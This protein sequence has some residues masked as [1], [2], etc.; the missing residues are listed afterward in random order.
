MTFLMLLATPWVKLGVVVAGMGIAVP[1]WALELG[2]LLVFGAGVAV[3]SL[4]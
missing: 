4:I 1:V 2:T 3:R